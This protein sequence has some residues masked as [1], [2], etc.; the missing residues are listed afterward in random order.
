MTTRNFGIRS[1]RLLALAGLTT[2]LAC[3]VADELLQVENPE[4]IPISDVTDKRLVDALVA[5]VIGDF[6]AM[7]DDPVIW[8]GSM[9]TDEQVTGINWE[10]TARLNLRI[11]QFNEG[12]A[13]GMFSALSRSLRQAEDVSERLRTLLD[14]PDSD[15][16]LAT[17][18]AFAGY[19]YTVMG[20]TMCECV[21][22][23]VDPVTGEII[24]GDKL[25]SPNDLFQT[26]MAR[27]QEAITVATAANDQKIL[28]L[29]R[30]GLA[31]A[32]LNAGDAAAAISAAMAVPT[33]FKYWLEYSSN[34]GRQENVLRD[35]V[36]GGN[37]ALGVHP[38]FLNGTFGTQGI[39]S[40]QTDPRIQHAS[41]WALG[42]NR[43]T[44]LY[45][46]FQGLRFEG[47]TGKTIAS[48]AKELTDVKLFE[49]ET[50]ILLA[51]YVDAQ[52]HRYEAEG[53]TAGTSAFIDARRAFGNQPALNFAAGDAAMMAELREQRG[54]DLYLGGFRLGDLRRWK[55][56]NVGDFFP[57][58]PHV[59][60]QWGL[61]SNATCY[62]LPLE[63]YEG[64]PNIKDLKPGE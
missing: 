43:L 41:K 45:K 25:L 29:A 7:Y 53:P 23:R 16:K 38:K 64:N 37:H 27:F 1:A 13:D 42:H 22:S 61:Y 5:G 31:R 52:H 47:Y 10:Q 58:G 32:A 34:T 18:L 2:L 57:S 9:F 59:N 4:E 12:D 21:I 40:T 24:L 3:S 33:T 39:V 15:A 28:N 56:T 19:A 48:G 54:R 8:R 36:T 35:R 55:R 46:P 60:A 20:E 62:P 14:N 30:V 63:E 44:K 26:A 50:N 49:R 6:T 17:T 51:D 11:V